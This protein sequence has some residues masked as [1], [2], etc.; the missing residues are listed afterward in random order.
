MSMQGNIAIAGYIEKTLKF[1]EDNKAAPNADLLR[2][3]KAD[4]KEDK[5][6]ADMG[7]Y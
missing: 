6:A 2:R 7:M 5:K 3:L 4:M 1:L